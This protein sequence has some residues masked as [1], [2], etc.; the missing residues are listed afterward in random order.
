MYLV[1][2]GYS[3]LV[4]VRTTGLGHNGIRYVFL[5]LQLQ[6]KSSNALTLLTDLGSHGGWV[7]PLRLQRDAVGLA[8]SKSACLPLILPSKGIRSGF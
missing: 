8:A 1:K 2:I 6:F 5:T 4:Q 3:L 7:C